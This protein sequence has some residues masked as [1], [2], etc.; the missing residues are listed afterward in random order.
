MNLH[1]KVLPTFAINSRKD[2]L[3]AYEHLVIKDLNFDL[4]P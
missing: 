1:G 2:D 3:T 4:C